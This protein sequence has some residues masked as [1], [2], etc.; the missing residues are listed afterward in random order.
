[1]RLHVASGIKI[2][3]HNSRVHSFDAAL[4]AMTSETKELVSRIPQCVG[5]FQFDDYNQ[6]VHHE[7]VVVGSSVLI[8]QFDS[9]WSGG[10]TSNIKE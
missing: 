8:V 4:E 3:R 5:C 1:M 7:L 2:S 6:L 9:V 10:F